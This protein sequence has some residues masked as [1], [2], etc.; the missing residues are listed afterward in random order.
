MSSKYRFRLGPGE[1]LILITIGV[2]ALIAL[3]GNFRVILETLYKP[4]TALIAV[5]MLVEY[6][7]LKGADRS[8]IYRRELEAAR[9]TRRAD[10][11]AMR[12]ME[13]RLVELRARL[14]PI[15]DDSTNAQALSDATRDTHEASDKVLEILRERI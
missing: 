9:E 3:T 8:H 12:N 5:I 2:L 6:V 11:L 15:L 14:T 7:I 4:Y 10:L 1:I 13:T